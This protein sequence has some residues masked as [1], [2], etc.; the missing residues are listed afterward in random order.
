M[1]TRMTLASRIHRYLRETAHR[2]PGFVHSG[3]FACTFDAQSDDPYVNYAIPDDGAQPSR[4]E[5]EALA[6]LFETRARRPR[7]EY[8]PGA[9][10]ALEEVL[11]D[12]GFSVEGRYPVMTCERVRAC[13]LPSGIEI[14]PATQARDFD[15]ASN[16]QAQAYGNTV[17]R[18]EVLRRIAEQG[19][20]VMLAED[21][22][23]A[24]PVGAGS[25]MAPI[26]GVS[27]LGG[28]GVVPQYRRLGIAAALTAALTQAIAENGATLVWLT[29]GDDGAGRVYQRAGFAK[30]CEALHI[31]RQ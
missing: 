2:G 26:D 22:R 1:L 29:P 17:P 24:L 27:E 6:A 31:S 3:Q 4:D 12:A 23:S 28:I 25:C 9:A 18:P 20:V 11:L 13:P 19:G 5:I 7:F 15:A 10:P 14:R 21:R 8:L 16:A 30:A